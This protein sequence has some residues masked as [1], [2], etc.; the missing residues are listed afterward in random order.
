MS[1]SSA[2]LKPLACASCR[3]FLRRAIVA[4]GASAWTAFASV[5][6]MYL[7]AM[8]KGTLPGPFQK[9]AGRP[10]TVIAT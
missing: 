6:A 9:T 7:R 2:T 5:M 3:S 8:V 4:S 1:A 10:P